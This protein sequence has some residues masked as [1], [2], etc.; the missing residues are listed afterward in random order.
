MVDFSK[1]IL[2]MI[3]VTF[4]TILFG[5]DFKKFTAFNLE[6]IAFNAFKVVSISTT[7]FDN[8]TLGNSVFQPF[9]DANSLAI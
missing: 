8:N 3:T 2:L 9:F 1:L 7:L 5:N 6:R 4:F